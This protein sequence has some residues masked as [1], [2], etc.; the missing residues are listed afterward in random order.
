MLIIVSFILTYYFVAIVQ[1]IFHKLF[2]HRNKIKVIYE[3]HALGHHDKYR[4]SNLLTEKWI[5]SEQHVMWYYAIPT[6]PIFLLLMYLSS[7]DIM[8]G[9]IC[10]LIFSVWWHIYL[11]EQYHIKGSYFE[12]YNWFLRKRK[13]HFLH[14]LEVTSNY[15]IVEFWIDDLL[16]TKKI[17]DV[18]SSL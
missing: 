4:P 18:Y 2:G 3:T 14:H 7:I 6:V 17:N 9:F 8:I 10:G 12:R 5:D 16:R 15:A 13:L 11:H 1:T